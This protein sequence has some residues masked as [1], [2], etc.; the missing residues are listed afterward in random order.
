MY[1]NSKYTYIDISLKISTLCVHIYVCMY[2][3]Y[4]TKNILYFHEYYIGYISY[5]YCISIYHI[6]Y[7]KD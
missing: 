4:I 1:H 5:T 7:Q 2:I 6:V 3:G